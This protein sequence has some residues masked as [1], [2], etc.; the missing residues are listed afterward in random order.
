VQR[1]SQRDAAALLAFV[2]ELRALD[3]PLPFPPQLL[4]GLGG[5]IAAKEVYY[6]ELDPVERSSV[7]Q[8]WHDADGN[9]VVRGDGVWS[10]D[11]RELWWSVRP[12]HPACGYRSATGDWTTAIKVSDFVSLPDFRRTAIY[13]AFYR[14]DVDH[15][16]DVGLS[17]EAAR[18]RVFIF[19][20]VGQDDFDERDRLVATLL[21][22]HLAR[23]ADEAEAALR[24]AE[25]LAAIEDGAIEEARRVVLC[26]N[27]GVIEFASASSRALLKQYLGL[28]NG[29]VPY[30]ILARRNLTLR[31]GDGT[32]E[33]R[34]ARTDNLYLLMLEERD[35]RI[36]KLSAREREV[37]DHVLLG[38]ANEAIAF[39]LGIARATVAKHLEHAYRKLGVQ[40]RTA[41]A[42]LLDSTR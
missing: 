32:L 39:H 12:T 14:G 28:A 2:S 35:A 30:S 16:L 5:L 23:R 24:A 36:E 4:S 34:V 25:A 33:L 18:T 31:A 40:N 7:L 15:W 17:P 8:V 6:S 38:K 1:L 11:E 21:Q 3:D 42:A 20:R 19:T 22:P 41:A 9:R 13:D 10:A 26:S 27:T 37:L 29:R